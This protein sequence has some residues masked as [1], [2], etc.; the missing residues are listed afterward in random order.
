VTGVGAPA[1][2][3]DG[4]FFGVEALAFAVAVCWLAGAVRALIEEAA[5]PHAA[6]VSI[7]SGASTSF[8]CLISCPPPPLDPGIQSC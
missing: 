4:V 3:E 5:L 2:G 8:A 6:S 1:A 7:A